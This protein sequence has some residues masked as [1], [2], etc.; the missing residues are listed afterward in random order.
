MLGQNQYNLN[1]SMVPKSMRTL[2][3]DLE[4][5]EQVM[6][7]KKGANLKAKGK[8]GTQRPKRCNSQHNSDQNCAT[9][10]DVL[11]ITVRQE[12]LFQRKVGRNST[13][14][15]AI[16]EQTLAV[17]MLRHDQNCSFSRISPN[18]TSRILLNFA[19]N[20]PQL[21]CAPIMFGCFIESYKIN[22]HATKN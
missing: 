19:Q 10:E 6:V 11:A 5:I 21:Q 16:L 15:K 17:S 7:E 20:L 2:L 18:L 4:A 14:N 9:I 8:G 3:P 1:H 12:F 22:V 13:E